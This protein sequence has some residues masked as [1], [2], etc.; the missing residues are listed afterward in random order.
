MSRTGRWLLIA[1][2]Y[3][4]DLVDLLGTMPPRTLPAIHGPVELVGRDVWGI[5][6][7]QLIRIQPG[8]L[9]VLPRAG[10]APAAT[11]QAVESGDIREELVA[12][13][14]ELYESEVITA[15]GGRVDGAGKM[16]YLANGHDM[17]S[18]EC[19]AMHTLW[20]NAVAWL[21]G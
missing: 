18:F 11:V 15:T 21:A 16:V 12:I 5:D 14:Q 13:V 10:A 19:D 7:A 1:R 2:G 6:G 17:R 8:D 9:S 3:D 4:V 20:S